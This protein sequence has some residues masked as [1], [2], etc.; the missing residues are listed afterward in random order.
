MKKTMLL[1]PAV[2]ILSACGGDSTPQ[3]P[4]AAIAQPTTI[5]QGEV[6]I[7][8]GAD[9]NS[10]VSVSVRS[11]GLASSLNADSVYRIDIPASEDDRTLV[12][13]LSGENV[14]EKS[15]SVYVPAN[16][17]SVVADVDLGAR[18]PPIEFSLDTGGTLMNADSP[19]RVSVSVPANAFLLPDGST[20][21]GDAQVSITEI[22]TQDWSSGSAW[23]PSLTGVRQNSTQEVALTSFGMSDF[24]F[25]QNGEK[26]Q[27]R[28]GAQATITMDLLTPYTILSDN[29]VPVA[30][31]EGDVIPLWYYSTTDM[32]WREEGE[33][34][35]VADAQ[36]DSGFSA[37][38]AV[39][40]FSTWSLDKWTPSMMIDVDIEI[41][42]DTGTRIEE[43]G[44]WIQSYRVV[45]RTVGPSWH[46]ESAW[47][48]SKDLTPADKKIMVLANGADRQELIDTVSYVEGFTEMDITLENVQLD[49]IYDS[50]SGDTFA[51]PITTRKIFRDYDGD[52]AIVFSLPID[53]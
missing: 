30:A 10:D 29:G 14:I 53:L 21:T 22:N 19:T 11:M 51:L 42:D 37:T 1:I 33:A 47:S 3:G 52:D 13:D 48:N 40:H 4:S 50:G 5:V 17:E 20:A 15:I 16:A 26:L 46:G 6:R 38:G 7:S 27:L 31:Q 41:V 34:R 2:L 18:T 36:S 45:A 43:S 8:Q 35:V 44:N 32:T 49:D 28:P 25:T 9:I 23:V 39:T 24:H 12:L